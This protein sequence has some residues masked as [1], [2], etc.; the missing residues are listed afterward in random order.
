MTS[1]PFIQGPAHLCSLPS[2]RSHRTGPPSLKTAHS[3]LQHSVPPVCNGLFHT[4]RPAN[5]YSI[6]LGET[7]VFQKQTN[8]QN[9]SRIHK[10]S[11]RWSSYTYFT[12]LVYLL[13]GFLPRLCL[14]WVSFSKTSSC[15]LTTTCWSTKWTRIL[16]KLSQKSK[17]SRKHD[18]WPPNSGDAHRA[19]FQAT[20]QGAL[21][22]GDRWR[23]LQKHPSAGLRTTSGSKWTLWQFNLNQCNKY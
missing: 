13:S 19:V 4:I 3:Q 20:V 9:L 18:L 7:A 22:D 1:S 5:F 16:A 15:A 8:K 12:V 10:A 17:E 11:F 23:E 2:Q 21:R 14:P 6:S